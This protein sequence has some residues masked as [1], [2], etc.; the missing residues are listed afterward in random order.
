MKRSIIVL[1][2]L[3]A[4]LVLTTPAMADD[5]RDSERRDSERR[6]EYGHDYR[7]KQG[8][9]NRYLPYEY[10]RH[11][12]RHSYRNEYHGHWR[13][14]GEFDHFMRRY[15]HLGRHGH[16]YHGGGRL[17]FR[18]CPPDSGMCIFFSIGH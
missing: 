9:R 6:Y 14:R 16:Y 15:P 7:G 5:R 1:C 17:M 8:H 11:H 2:A 18:T 3:V 10:N 13:S 12:R 4:G